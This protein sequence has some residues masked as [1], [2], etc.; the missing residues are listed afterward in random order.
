MMG[1]PCPQRPYDMSRRSGSFMI[2]MQPFG[3]QDQPSLPCPKEMLESVSADRGDSIVL[4]CDM[5]IGLS[6]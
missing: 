1:A 6:F 2:P 3:L 5:L 4:L